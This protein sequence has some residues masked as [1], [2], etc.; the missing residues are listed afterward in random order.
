MACQGCGQSSQNRLCCPTCIE[1]GRTTFFCSQECF[2]NNWKPHCQLHEILKKKKM[3][4]ENDAAAQGDAIAPPAGGAVA[5]VPQTR[6]EPPPSRPA[7]LPGGMPLVS[8]LGPSRRSA[9]VGAQKKEDGA[10][11][12]PASLLGSFVGQAWTAIGGQAAKLAG[13]NGGS[14]NDTGGAGLRPGASGALRSRLRSRSPAVRNNV[15]GSASAATSAAQAPHI[16]FVRTGVFSLAAIAFVGGIFMYVGHT[17]HL[18]EGMPEP[19]IPAMAAALRGGGASSASGVVTVSDSR[20]TAVSD[21]GGESA[22]AAF[23]AELGVLREEVERHGKMLRYIMDR[24]VEKDSV[25]DSSEEA[26]R[27]SMAHSASMVNFSAPEF[28]SKSVSGADSELP[29]NVEDLAMKRKRRG[30]PNDGSVGLALPEKPE[31]PAELVGP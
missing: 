2:T 3:L 15:T 28:I 4:E 8:S 17:R 13:S 10:A 31:A 19:A 22:D 23:R 26:R 16:Q 5:A 21:V 25:G 27:K 30:G 12:P 1:Y 7:P 20:S 6:Q 18:D 24:Y 29:A 14:R 11:G 9:A